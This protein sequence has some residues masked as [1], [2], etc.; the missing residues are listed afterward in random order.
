MASTEKKL[1]KDEEL[2]GRYSN[3]FGQYLEKEYISKKDNLKK[4]KTMWYL[5]HFP[6]IYNGKVRGAF[7][8][9]SKTNVLCLDDVIHQSSKFQRD[10]CAVLRRFRIYLVALVCDVAEMYLRIGLAPQN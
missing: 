5:S 7:D 2:A 6:V 4:D 9:A 8:A 10:L 3:I 1:F